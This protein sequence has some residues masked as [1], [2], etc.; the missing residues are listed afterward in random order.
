MIIVMN[1][2]ISLIGFGGIF[3]AK[4]LVWEG[5]GMGL[6]SHLFILALKL[7]ISSIIIGL[8]LIYA[9]KYIW[10][11]LILSGLINIIIFHFIEAFATQKKLLHKRE[12]NV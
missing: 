11:V 8:F 3:L 6:K 12:V 4:H 1:I 9:E 10:T 2:I 5:A 7:I